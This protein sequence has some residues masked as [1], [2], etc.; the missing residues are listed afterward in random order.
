MTSKQPS[1]PPVHKEQRESTAEDTQTQ[2]RKETNTKAKKQTFE[3]GGK[4]S[5]LLNCGKNMSVCLIYPYWLSYHD[6]QR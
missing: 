2:L 3:K 5:S 4:K 6:K 1:V